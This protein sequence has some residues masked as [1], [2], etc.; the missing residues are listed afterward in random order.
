MAVVPGLTSSLMFT[1]RTVIFTFL[2]LMVLGAC[3]AAER[4]DL[5]VESYGKLLLIGADG[6]QRTLAPLIGLTALSPD[7][8][9]IAFTQNENPR[10]TQSPQNGT[11]SARL[12]GRPTASGL[13]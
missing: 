10:E 3:L 11:M 6:T 4:G 13:P 1:K 8:G 5:L 12:R 7:G 9:R 2:T